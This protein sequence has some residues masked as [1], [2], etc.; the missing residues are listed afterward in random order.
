MT[1]T[2][3]Q[4]AKLAGVSMGTASQAL[5]NNS[6]VSPETRSRVLDAARTLGYPIKANNGNGVVR[7][8]ISVVGM[9]AK[10]DVDAPAMV[11]P[12]YSHIYSGVEAE[13]RRRGL[14]LM[15]SDIEVGESNH[16]IGWPVMLEKQHID[17]LILVGTFI[18]DTLGFIE[19]RVKNFPTVLI[20]SYAK[21]LSFDSVLTSNFQGAEQAIEHLVG[22]GHTC[23]GL[24][25]SY[26]SS[27]PSILERREGVVQTLKRLGL[28]NERYIEDSDLFRAAGHDA[29]LRLLR[30]CPEVTAIMACNDDTATGVYQ[31]G[32]EL[33]LKIPEDLSVVGFDNINLSSELTPPL[34]TIHVHKAWMGVLGV[35][36]LLERA[37]YPEKPQVNVLVSTRLLVRES[38]ASPKH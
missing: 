6:K 21:R 33:Q 12:F 18:E 29:T 38:T 31:A 16:P 3:N 32:R 35:Q 11:N 25:G 17:G 27:P 24:V 20:D 23:I 22:L 34:T 2:L 30:R 14:S 10:H 19:E 15:Y 4:V 1:V 26:V 37:Q 7:T 13:C 28:Y 9:V 8:S 36:L 5:N